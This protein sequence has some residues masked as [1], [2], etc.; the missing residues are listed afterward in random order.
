MVIFLD[1]LND[2]ARMRL[3]ELDQIPG[4]GIALMPEEARPATR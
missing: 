3:R 1:P 2:D 4:P